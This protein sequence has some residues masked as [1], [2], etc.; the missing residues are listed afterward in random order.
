MF[1]GTKYNNIHF[2]TADNLLIFQS[3]DA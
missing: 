2:Q 3:S 1:S